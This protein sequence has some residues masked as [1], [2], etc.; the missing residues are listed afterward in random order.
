MYSKVVRTAYESSKFHEICSHVVEFAK[1]W[2]TI[3]LFSE[4]A[5]EHSHK[6]VT[7]MEKNFLNIANP[8]ERLGRVVAEWELR[9][10]LKCERIFLETYLL[11]FLFQIR[12]WLF[13]LEQ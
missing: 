7:K 9:A 8:G 12:C 4:Q 11:Y 6:L 3:G 5:T 10:Y 2:K 1:R 13:D